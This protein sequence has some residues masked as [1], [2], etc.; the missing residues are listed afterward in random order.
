MLSVRDLAVNFVLS[1]IITKNYTKDGN[2]NV[3]FVTQVGN[4]KCVFS[5]SW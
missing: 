2:L 3:V 5:Q 1:S 4:L